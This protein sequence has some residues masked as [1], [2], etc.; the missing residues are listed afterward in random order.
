[1][2][3]FTL[4]ARREINDLSERQD[5]REANDMIVSWHHDTRCHPEAFG[6]YQTVLL[7]H[8]LLGKE[9]FRMEIFEY[10]QDYIIIHFWPRVIVMIRLFKHF[11]GAA[12]IASDTP[13]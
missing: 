3:R 9:W 5:G 2:V 11:D 6:S 7:L 13:W 4:Y 1:M 12:R 8:H 10:M